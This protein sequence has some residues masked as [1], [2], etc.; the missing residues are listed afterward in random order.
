MPRLTVTAPTGW[1]SLHRPRVVTGPLSPG[2]LYCALRFPHVPPRSLK[3]S[4]VFNSPQG[5]QLEGAI[6]FLP[7]PPETNTS[8]VTLK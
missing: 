1:P 3:S 7:G 5:T 8:F 4:P 2:A 6:S